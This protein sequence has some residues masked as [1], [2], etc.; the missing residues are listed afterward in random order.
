MNIWLESIGLIFLIV[1]AL[2][3]IGYG[4]YWSF[5]VLSELFSIPIKAFFAVLVLYLLWIYRSSSKD[6]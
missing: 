3:A 4:T 1:I 6:K 2:G 5:T